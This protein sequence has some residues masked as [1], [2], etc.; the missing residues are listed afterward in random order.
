ME[1]LDLRRQIDELDEELI[2]LLNNRA[3]VSLKIGR[4]KQE[5]NLPVYNSAR[6]EDVIQKVKEKNSGPLTEENIVS[7]FKIIIESCRTL[8]EKEI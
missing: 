3:S 4:K 7:I 8:Q 1:L 2:K 5:E 6:E